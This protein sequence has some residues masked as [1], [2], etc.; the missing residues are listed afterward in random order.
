MLKSDL[1]VP[2]LV[3]PSI[4]HIDYGLLHQGIGIETLC[5]DCDNT[6]V[7][8]FGTVVSREAEILMQQLAGN[9]NICIISNTIFW[10]FNGRVRKIAESLG[11]E[12]V[13]CTLPNRKPRKW[14][15]KR[16]L[17][18]TGCDDPSKAAMIG[19]QP[20]TDIIGG[21]SLGLYTVLVDRMGRDPWWM[22][23]TGKRKREAAL[24]AA[25]ANCMT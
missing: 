19:D 20:Y 22:A 17:E 11:T 16:A 24:R 23:L 14:G 4:F 15:F 18:L 7:P 12:C 13:C 2:D 1:F 8:A 25:I 9:F 6:I 3:A 10:V 21:N 5:F